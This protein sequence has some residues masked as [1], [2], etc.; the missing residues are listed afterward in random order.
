[1]QNAEQEGRQPLLNPQMPE[2]VVVNVLT[3][4]HWGQE[5]HD[6]LKSKLVNDTCQFPLAGDGVLLGNLEYSGGLQLVLRRQKVFPIS[7]NYF[8]SQIWNF[9]F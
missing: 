2:E 7:G 3:I 1:M 8:L 5:A 9:P 4:Q 6:L